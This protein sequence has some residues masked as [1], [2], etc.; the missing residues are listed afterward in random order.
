MKRVTNLTACVFPPAECAE[1]AEYVFRED[2][3]YALSP[4]ADGE[5]INQCA[6]PG[7]ILIVG[8][9]EA[10]PMEFPHMVSTGTG[11]RRVATKTAI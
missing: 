5:R 1:Y 9:E 6:V 8:G 2:E 3:S 4:L 7:E 10:N 11:S